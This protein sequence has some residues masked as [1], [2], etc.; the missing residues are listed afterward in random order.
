MSG[1]KHANA[2]RMKAV[3]TQAERFAA[4]VEATETLKE[5]A[6]LARIPVRTAR[7]YRQRIG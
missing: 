4:Y 7:R 5:A 6:W 1:W 3:Q 2:A